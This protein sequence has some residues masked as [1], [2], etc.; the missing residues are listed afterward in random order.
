MNSKK[1]LQLNYEIIVSH[2]VNCNRSSFWDGKCEKTVLE[3]M[4][5]D[6]FTPLKAS[7]YITEKYIKIY[8]AVKDFKIFLAI[9]IS[10]TKKR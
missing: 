2:Y 5:Y 9:V 6:S 10:Q 3:L 1:L 7:I 8:I 4:N